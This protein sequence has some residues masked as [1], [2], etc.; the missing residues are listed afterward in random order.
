MIND[1]DIERLFLEPGRPLQGFVPIGWPK[2]T[3]IRFECYLDRY[4]AEANGHGTF[5]LYRESSREMSDT[6]CVVHSCRVGEPFHT[7]FNTSHDKVRSIEI[8]APELTSA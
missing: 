1:K 4:I 7:G 8:L 3:I 5:T 6:H 2:G